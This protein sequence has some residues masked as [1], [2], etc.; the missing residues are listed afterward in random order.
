MQRIV[1]AVYLMALAI[2]VGSV[3]FHSFVVAPTLF[4]SLPQSTAGDVVARIFPTYYLIGY[5]CGAVATIAP[6]LLRGSGTG[7]RT[8]VWA[9]IV[10]ATMLF[11]TIVGGAVIHPRAAALRSGLAAAAADSPERSQFRRLHAAA[12]GAN[13]LVL[14]GGLVLVVIVSRHLRW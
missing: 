3:I 9:S 5:V 1:A 12:V 14:T 6:W 8:V 7:E 11:A 10:A 4:R 2:W 13:L